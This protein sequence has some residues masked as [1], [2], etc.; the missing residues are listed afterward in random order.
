M[1]R[2]QLFVKFDD[3][4]PQEQRDYYRSIQNDN[5]E[6]SGFDLMV[7]KEYTI[8]TD[9]NVWFLNFNV[10]CAMYDTVEKKYV[11]YYLYP[12]SSFS[13]Y[14]L[15]M[16][17]HVGIIDAGYRGNIMGAVRLYTGVS[18]TPQIIEPSTRLFQLCAPDL[19]PFSV[20]IVDTLP[21]SIRGTGGFGSTGK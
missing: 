5:I 4:L 15:I 11:G 12:R 9:R 21:D 18:N 3:S 16:A 7:D 13:K 1:T 8:S 19:S 10:Q 6:D 17:N 14:R 2:Y 20:Q